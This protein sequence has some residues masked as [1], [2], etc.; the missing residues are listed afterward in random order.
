M[1]KLFLAILLVAVTGLNFAQVSTGFTSFTYGDVGG[2]YVVKGAFTADSV[3]SAFMSDA[4][5]LPKYDGVDYGTYPVQFRFKKTS[6]YVSGAKCEIFLLG[7]HQSLTDTVTLDTIA[8][9]YST[10]ESDSIGVLYLNGTNGTV[11]SGYRLFIRP[12]AANDINSATVTLIWR[13]EE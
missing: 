4:F 2:S 8:T 6:T 3:G 5:V 10:T 13:K 11:A 12:N 1:K 9:V 7:Y